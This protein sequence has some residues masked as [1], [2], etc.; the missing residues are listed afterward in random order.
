MAVCDAMQ[1]HQRA[2]RAPRRATP[3]SVLLGGAHAPAVLF[4]NLCQ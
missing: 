4:L 3:V 2:D 1:R